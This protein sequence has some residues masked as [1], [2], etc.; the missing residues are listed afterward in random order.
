MKIRFIENRTVQA[1]GGDS[2][3]AGKI[4]DLPETSCR[5]WLARGCAELVTE[6]KPK[7]GSKIEE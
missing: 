2:F 6:E 5:H 3:L 1:D 7:R 4:Y